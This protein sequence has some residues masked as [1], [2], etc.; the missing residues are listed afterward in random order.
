MPTNLA[1]PIHWTESFYQ[2]KLVKS[3]MEG[4]SAMTLE[5]KLKAGFFKTLRY[6]LTIGRGQISLIP[7]DAA[8]KKFVIDNNELISLCIFKKSNQTGELEI[9]AQSR[10]YTLDFTIQ[11]NLDDVRQAFAKEFGNKFIS[12]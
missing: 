4:G 2:I 6:H 9:V 1:M 3:R 11:S 7:R 5:V 12:Q 8:D 10:V